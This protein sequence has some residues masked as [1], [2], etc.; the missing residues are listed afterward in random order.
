KLV[1]PKDCFYRRYSDDLVIICKPEDVNDVERIVFEEIKKIKLSISKS[2]TEK[3]RFKNVNNKLECFKIKDQQLISNSY[4]QYLGF[5]FYGH[6]TLVK[7]ANIS[8]FYREMKESIAMKAKRIEAVQNK[9]L[10]DEAIIFKRKIYRLYSFRGI[11]SRTLPACQIVY[12]NGKL[13]KEE[14]ER[15]YRGNFVKYAYRASEIMEAPEIK[16]QLR[17]HMIILKRY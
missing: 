8:R 10:I 5:D 3:F 2:K 15:K 11:K 9:N 12:K 13:T 4:L 16:R 17:R 7:A 1:K 14:F 6:K